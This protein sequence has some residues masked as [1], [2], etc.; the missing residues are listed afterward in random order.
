[1][2]TIKKRDMGAIAAAAAV[3]APSIEDR[4]RHAKETVGSHPAD[5]TSDSSFS[6]RKN[7]RGEGSL[8]STGAQLMS[9]DLALV[10]D[11]PFNARCVYKPSRITELAASISAH[12]QEQPGVAAK[13]GGRFVLAAGHYRKKALLAVGKSTID[14]L[15]YPE[16]SDQE[17]YAHSYRENGE[18]EAQTSLDNAMAWKNLLDQKV[19]A[20]ATAI[21]VATGIS[22][23]NV[24]KTLR[25]LDLSPQ[26]LDVVKEE[27]DAF[28]LSVLYELVLFEKD[29]GTSNAIDM[30]VRVRSGEASR[31]DIEEARKHA[32]EDKK[33]RKLKE[34]SRQ[35]K[36]LRGGKS[37]GQLKDWDS[38]KVSFEVL[39][40]DPKERAALVDELRAKFGLAQD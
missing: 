26:V 15:V 38:G 12:G 24:T 19:F 20:D 36:I 40:E 32:G 29:A 28:P 10:D 23:P 27:P 35:Y 21:S 22:L 5:E 6:S 14:L 30:A 13:R 1:M 18:R 25:A 16:M 7:R 39:L 9:V 37:V 8:T 2:A 4:L 11:N 31:R 33:P 34:V 3:R 17:L